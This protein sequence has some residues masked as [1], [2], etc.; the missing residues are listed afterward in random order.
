M[1]KRITESTRYLCAAVQIDEKFC[2]QILDEILEEDYTAIGICHGVDLPTILKSCLLAK[3]RRKDRDIPLAILVL[4]GTLFFF[5]FFPLFLIFYG[6]AW[7]IVFLD[8]RN[9]RYEIVGKNLLRGNFNPN[10]FNSP[11]NV[12]TK[13]NLE[14]IARTQDANVIIY[15]GF[16]P[17]VGAG[18]NI[19]GWSFAV[20]TSKG[21]ENMGAIKAPLPFQVSE[22]YDYIANS[23]FRLD[24][25]N[26][27]IEDNLYV[28]GE[29]I[30]D[31]EDFLPNPL[32]RPITKVEDSFI[33]SFIENPT[34][35]A[36]H[37][38]CIRVTD[39]KGELIL[40][41]FLRFSKSG[42]NL[43]VEA[44]YYLLTPLNKYYRQYDQIKPEPSSEDIRKM[45]LETLFSTFSFGISSITSVFQRFNN[46][47]KKKNQR[48]EKE[49]EIKSNY[50]FNYGA[51]TSLRER[52]SHS[53]AYN[54]YFQ[55]LDKEMYLKSIES[56]IVD[57][58]SKFLDTKNIDTSDFKETRSTILNHGVMVSGGSVQTQNLTVGE[59]AKSI[60]SNIGTGG[61]SSGS[62]DSK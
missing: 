38:R 34:H 19:G 54:R 43:F 48:K 4:A 36:R 22:L 41:I 23:I 30:R 32:M 39:W 40:S 24:L 16:S 37:Y 6:I 44:N 31:R 53:N 15:G 45:A 7:R 56:R 50:A 11:L 59:R 9:T 5:I 60:I 29:E 51:V 17:F 20:D 1:N 57:G 58:L 18:V 47:R 12:K 55:K 2:D 28:N 27:S 33:K 61:S 8:Q 25:E 52:V 46:S 35:F 21:K 14:E 3:N 13:K 62:S 26:L 49:K 42:Q 10:L